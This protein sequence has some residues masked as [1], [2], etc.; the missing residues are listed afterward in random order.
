MSAAYKWY[1]VSLPKKG[2]GL[3]KLLSKSPLLADSEFGF[4]VIED[5]KKLPKLRFLR[6]TKVVVTRVSDEGLPYIEEIDGVDFV[7]FAVIRSYTT[8]YLRLE[9]PGHGAK[10]LFNALEIIL[11]MGFTCEII[12][13]Q[14][15]DPSEIFEGVESAK[16]TGFSVSGAVADQDLIARLE[17]SSKKGMDIRKIRWLK[18]LQYKTDFSAFEIIYRGLR[19]QISFSS[20]GS[21][22]VSG[23]LSPRLIE[24]VDKYISRR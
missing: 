21:V 5:D 15:S 14:S 13:L 18:G 3:A 11:G 6:R 24:Q 10:H 22:K 20:S 7:D 2:V 1:R 12:K 9:N 8:N 16:L 23:P 19:G 4:V 17:F